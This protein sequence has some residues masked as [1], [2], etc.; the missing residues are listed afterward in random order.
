MAEEKIE[1]LM[2]SFL[3][4]V[5]EKDVDKAVSLCAEDAVWV[6]PIGTFKGRDELKR[7]ITW[8]N[9]S[10]PDM[11]VTETGIGI[12][13]RGNTG[14]YEHVLSGTFDGMKWEVLAICVYEFSG[15][16]VKNIRTV[17]DRLLLAKQATKGMLAKKAV[18]SI[19]ENMSKGLR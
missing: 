14:V 5:V 2:R 11:K 10:I 15:E 18:N 4:A 16:K 9:Q 12:M 7:Y 1:G 17:Y 13:A 8:L 6:N 3:K 19:I